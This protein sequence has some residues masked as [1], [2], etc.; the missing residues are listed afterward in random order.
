[1]YCVDMDMN[2][3]WAPERQ[4]QIRHAGRQSQTN[5]EY[6]ATAFPLKHT[7]IDKPNCMS[8][9]KEK[10][11]RNT[12]TNPYM[13]KTITARLYLRSVP[14]PQPRV[15]PSHTISQWQGISW[16]ELLR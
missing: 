6:Q 16:P 1:M 12:H 15:C 9:I 5:R 7:N 11:H 8:H 3:A 10:K 2:W 13:E 14:L 4:M